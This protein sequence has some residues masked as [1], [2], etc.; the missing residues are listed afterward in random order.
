MR[1]SRQI[2][3]P[4]IGQRPTIVWLGACD[5][6]PLKKCRHIC[7]SFGVVTS[8]DTTIAPELIVVATERPGD[9]SLAEIDDLRRRFPTAGVVT[10][11]GAWCEG[12]TRTGRPALGTIRIYG[13]EAAEWLERQFALY[14][15]GQCSAWG[16]PMSQAAEERWLEPAIYA[17]IAHHVRLAV[18][19]PSPRWLATLCDSLAALGHA[20]VGFMPGQIPWLGQI[21]ALVWDLPTAQTDRAVLEVQRRALPRVPTIALGDFVR[22]HD[23]TTCR[24]WG[25]DKVLRKPTRI[26]VL[27]EAIEELVTQ[28]A[29]RHAA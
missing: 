29:Q 11:V 25:I 22:E 1:H 24:D 20:T 2:I 8:A 5:S 23:E 6:S 12:E 9:V 3:A 14:T 7:E 21:D 17:P 15:L 16:R 27:A 4:P 10:L 18:C 26:D 19:S 28:V 13:Y